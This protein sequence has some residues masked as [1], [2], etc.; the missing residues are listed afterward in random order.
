L[1]DESRATISHAC[2]AAKARHF[3]FSISLISDLCVLQSFA[4]TKINI[5]SAATPKQII[6]LVRLIIHPF[7]FVKNIETAPKRSNQSGGL[8]TQLQPQASAF[9]VLASPATESAHESPPGF[10]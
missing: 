2:D 8:I 5:S 6:F 4:L 9:S 10:E 1:F 3:V 7:H